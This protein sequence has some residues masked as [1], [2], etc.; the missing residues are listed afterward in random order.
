MG[1]RGGAKA[2][3]YSILMCYPDLNHAKNILYI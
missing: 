3:P 1:R 2:P